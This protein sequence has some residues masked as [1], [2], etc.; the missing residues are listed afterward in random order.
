MTFDLDIRHADSARHCWGPFQ[1]IGQ[2]E[3]TR[4]KRARKL[5]KWQTMSENQNRIENG[6]Y[7][8]T[9]LLCK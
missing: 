4:R 9:V 7:S 6:K 8:V 3:I 2:F 1:V 5:L